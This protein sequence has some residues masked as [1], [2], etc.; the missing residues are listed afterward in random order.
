MLAK[1]VAHRFE[2][3]HSLCIFLKGLILEI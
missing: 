3:E 1:F 2:S